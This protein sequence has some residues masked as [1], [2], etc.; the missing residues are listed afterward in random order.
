[1]CSAVLCARI[2][3]NW[4]VRV[5]HSVQYS[6]YLL[7][8]S[9]RSPKIYCSVH[10]YSQRI[11]R[12][13]THRN[14]T[15]SAP[16]CTRIPYIYDK[17]LLNLPEYR[18]VCFRNIC[19]FHIIH[20]DIIIILDSFRCTSLIGIDCFHLSS[21]SISSSFTFQLDSTRCDANEQLAFAHLSRALRAAPRRAD[22]PEINT[23]CTHEINIRHNAAAGGGGGD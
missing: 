11:A 20:C 19:Y 13:A 17:L 15:R 14:A 5:V 12:T 8:H 4:F 18:T 7:T 6:N 1:M 9:T 2:L 3:G 21:L 23:L 22:L 10:I 16:L